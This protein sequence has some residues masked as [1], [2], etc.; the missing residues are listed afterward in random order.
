MLQ[1]THFVKILHMTV[2]IKWQ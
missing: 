1:R 2:N